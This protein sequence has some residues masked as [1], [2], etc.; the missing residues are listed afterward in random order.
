MAGSASLGP[1]LG[2]EFVDGVI[3][4]SREAGERVVKVSQRIDAPA[5]A[6]FHDGVE[7]GGFLSGFGCPYEEEVLLSYGGRPDGI[8]DDVMLSIS[9]RP[10]VR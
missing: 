10:A 7:D 8:L 6:G 1:V 4:I 2:G 3:G 9:T 5:A